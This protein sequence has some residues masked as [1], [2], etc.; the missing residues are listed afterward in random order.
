MGNFFKKGSD[1]LLNGSVLGG[2]AGA[3]VVWGQK[4]YDV[5]VPMIPE[6]W[7]IFGDYSIPV[8]IIAAGVLIGYLVDRI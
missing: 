2:I 8:I 7:Q 6:T 4:V 1:G 5:V 3:L